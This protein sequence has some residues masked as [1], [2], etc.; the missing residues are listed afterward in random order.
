VRHGLSTSETRRGRIEV[1][2]R[3]KECPTTRFD[4]GEE[5]LR[6]ADLLQVSGDMR[7]AKE[8][9]GERRCERNEWL[10]KA[11]VY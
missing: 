1:L 3:V 10:T 11:Q 2:E 8:T 9:V 7:K 6:K 4:I 5:R